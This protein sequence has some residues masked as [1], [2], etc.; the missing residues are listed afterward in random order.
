MVREKLVESKPDEKG[1]RYCKICDRKLRPL[2]KAKDWE[3]RCYHVTCFRELVK[4][5]YRYDKIAYNKY[6]HKQKVGGKFIDEFQNGTDP[7]VITFD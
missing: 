6:R 5:I 4:D 7:I 3:Q 1:D 2:T